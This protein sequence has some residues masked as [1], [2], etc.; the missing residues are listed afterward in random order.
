MKGEILNCLSSLYSNLSVMKGFAIQQIIASQLT[1]EIVKT[2]NE[3][4]LLCNL[5]EKAP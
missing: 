4:H 3:I 1:S 5:V 2:I